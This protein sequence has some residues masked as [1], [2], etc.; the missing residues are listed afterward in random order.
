MTKRVHVAIFG[1]SGFVGTSAAQALEARGAQV[2]RLAAPR[3]MPLPHAEVADFVRASSKLREEVQ[4]S[5]G[6]ATVIVNAAGI[7]DASSND[8][9]LLMAANA[10]CAALL[11]SAARDCGVQ[12]FVHV[13][14]AV[15]QGDIDTLDETPRVHP[16]SAYSRSKVLGEALVAEFGPSGSV[17]YRPPSVH[18][19]D[20]RVTQ[21]IH[22]LATSSLS[23][24][25]AP[26]DAPSPQALIQ[27]VADAVAYL[28]LCPAP[29]PPV[30]IHPWEGI[31]TSGLLRLLGRRD[32][33]L[34][35]PALARVIR[36]TLKSAS[37]GLPRLEA[38]RR[39]ME[40]LWFGQP[41]ASSWL[42][43]AGWTP[44]VGLEGW[45]QL[46]DQVSAPTRS[47]PGRSALRRRS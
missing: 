12:R 2:T 29:P 14:S 32:P 38:N 6:G 17:V 31:T 43:R 39:R 1:A 16:F 30:V 26:G 37:H 27:N 25:V 4:V 35:H 47:M 23:A 34:L 21:M 15:V 9:P 24:T 11:S 46:F 7:P 44:P 42:S 3:L 20:R 33:R 10:A 19:A 8:E 18:G 28:A 40:L 45:D 5:M 13:S 36:R 41:Q 22:K